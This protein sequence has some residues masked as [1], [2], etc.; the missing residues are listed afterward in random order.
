MATPTHSTGLCGAHFWSQSRST[1]SPF[2]LPLHQLP[3]IS[4]PV[5]GSAW[6][7]PTHCCAVSPSLCQLCKGHSSLAE[8]VQ[9]TKTQAEREGFDC[10]QPC[11]EVVSRMISTTRTAGIDVRL[12]GLS[13]P[14]LSSESLMRLGHPLGLLQTSDA[15]HVCGDFQRE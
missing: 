12:R 5:P 7:K 13:F 1:W 14:T 11:W 4:Q 10:P 15:F 8:L 6:F 9:K 3:C 2:S